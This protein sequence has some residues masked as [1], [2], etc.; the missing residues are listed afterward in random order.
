VTLFGSNCKHKFSIISRTKA[1]P[2]HEITQRRQLE[3]EILRGRCSMTS[4]E[5]N[6]QA[7][8]CTQHTNIKYNILLIFSFA[9][10]PLLYKESH[11]HKLLKNHLPFTPIHTSRWRISANER[12]IWGEITMEASAKI[13]ITLFFVEPLPQPHCGADDEPGAPPTRAP[14][15]TRELPSPIP[16]DPLGSA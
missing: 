13:S 10:R 15:S 6:V 2:K 1:T 12:F 4:H 5:C 7:S 3:R 16:L 11:M 9:Y 14:H 8:K